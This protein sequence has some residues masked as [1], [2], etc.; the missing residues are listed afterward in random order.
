MRWHPSVRL[1]RQARYGE[2]GAVIG[3]IAAALPALRG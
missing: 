2:W 1:F 3:A